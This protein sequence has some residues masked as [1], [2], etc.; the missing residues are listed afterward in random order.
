MGKIEFLNVDVEIIVKNFVLRNLSY[1]R[2]VKVYIYL[3]DL[4]IKNSVFFLDNFIVG[5]YF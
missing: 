1:G 3:N 5:M 4:N 2:K